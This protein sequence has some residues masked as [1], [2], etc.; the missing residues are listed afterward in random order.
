MSYELSYISRYLLYALL[1]FSPLARGGVQPWSVAV[2]EI[3]TLIA[4]ALFLIERSLTWDWKW[5]RTP[6]DL[7]IVCLL[8]LC[9][10]SVAFSV[11]RWTSLYSTIL[12][13]NYIVILYLTIHLTGTRS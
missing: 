13:I 8:V 10:L 11:H 5:I 9:L 2:I 3:A 6:L 12:L 4:L 1:V 7:P